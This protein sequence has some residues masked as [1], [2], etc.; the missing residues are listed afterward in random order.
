MSDED[1]ESYVDSIV[2]KKLKKLGVVGGEETEAGSLIPKQI[3]EFKGAI[4]MV[5]DLSEAT[6]GDL[7]KIISEGIKEKMAEQI[8]PALFGQQKSSGSF[9]DSGFMQQLGRGLGE[10]IPE[11]GSIM[12]DSLTKNFGKDGAEKIIDKV[13]S[14][15]AGAGGVG[16]SDGKGG[17]KDENED[18]IGSLDPDNP[19]HLHYYM[20]IRGL[21]GVSADDARKSL[22]T[23]KQSIVN[24]TKAAVN[25][26]NAD[27]AGNPG[28]AGNI[29][30]E[31]AMRE[32][33]I[34][35][36]KIINK[37]NQSDEIIKYL[38]EK[39]EKIDGKGKQSSGTG[40][41]DDMES[42]KSSDDAIINKVSESWDK[43]IE[44]NKEI[45]R[46]K[47]K[48]EKERKER[49]EQDIRKK[50]LEER[51]VVIGCVGRKTKSNPVFEFN[52]ASEE[53]GEIKEV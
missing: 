38:V 36:E 44:K 10:K 17:K 18:T 12:I 48:E 4:S 5:K 25:V 13:M 9:M 47:E 3:K 37:Q 6:R 39:I 30:L 43:D 32:Q 45:I 21:S 23:E 50:E 34:Y 35:L 26:N 52:E 49:E 1:V 19:N 42:V 51:V 46:Q 11:Y 31:N 16:S 2:E 28:N 29:T 41:A 15:S 20:S 40:A 24:K 7:D 33:N 14:A 53:N 8:V 22:I 27:N